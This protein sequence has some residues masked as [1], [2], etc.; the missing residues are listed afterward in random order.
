MD[1]LLVGD[2][3]ERIAFVADNPGKWLIEG[4]ALGRSDMG[5]AV[6]FVVE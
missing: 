5:T 4:R 2:E 6:W 1:T 3:I